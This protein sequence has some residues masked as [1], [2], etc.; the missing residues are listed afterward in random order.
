MNQNYSDIKKLT[1]DEQ[2]ELYNRIEKNDLI[3]LLINSNEHIVI[4][5]KLVEN[6]KNL[7]YL[8]L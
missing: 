5:S 4:L 3:E 1:I 6:Y 2:R 7:Y 8:N